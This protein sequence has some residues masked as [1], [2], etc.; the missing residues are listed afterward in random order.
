MPPPP[1]LSSAPVAKSAAAA[2]A[3]AR[4]KRRVADR[5]GTDRRRTLHTSDK[6]VE[7][8]SRAEQLRHLMQA[9]PLLLGS[10][11]IHAV[12]ICALSPGV[13]PDGVLLGWLVGVVCL[14]AYCLNGWWEWKRKEHPPF[15]P[16]R[17]LQWV[18]AQSGALGLAWGTVPAWLF[19][20]AEPAHQVLLGTG[21][22]GMLSAGAFCLA[23]VPLAVQA[24]LGVL[25]LG[26]L[27]AF[28]SRPGDM[29]VFGVLQWLFYAVVAIVA[30]RAMGKHLT[31]RVEADALNEH[32]Q[33]LIGLLLRDFEEQGSDVIWEI[34]AKGRLVQVSK[35]LADALGRP[36]ENV[37]GR[38]FLGLLADLQVSL[39]ENDRESA[40]A[41][42]NRLTEGQPFRDVLLP[43]V[44]RGSVHWW[45]VTAKPLVDDRRAALG[46]RGVARDVTQ[47]RMADRRL[48]WLA[49]YD[50]L[51]GLTNRAHFRVV[52]ETA[53]KTATAR[54]G[55]GAVMCL[56]LDNF[57]TVN[58]TLGHATGD[59]LL[60]EVG[61]RVKSA[62]DKTDVVARLGG[63]EFAVLLKRAAD[64]ATVQQVADRIILAMSEPCE[65]LGAVVPVRASIG[66]AR[67]PK[68]GI[69]VDEMMQHA[70]LALYDAKTHQPGSMRFFA[71][72]MGEQIRRRLVL[73]RD[74][75]E[76]LE[77][78]Q[79]SLHFQPKVDLENWEVQGFEA[80]LRWKH[81]EHG[82]IPPVEFIP[83][84]EESGLILPMGEW[85]L[86]EACRQAATWPDHLQVAVNISPVQVMAQN[87][88]NAIRKALQESRLQPDRL[89]LEITESV[90]INETSGTV[91]QLHALRKLGVQIALD[92]FGT[93]YSSLAYLRRFPFDTL[94]IDRAF[95][96]ELL[97][98]R[99][100]RAI[101]RNIL[102]LASSLRMSTV[103][104]GVEEPA[105]VTVL[106][107][108][109][110]NLVQGYF[111][112][113]PIPG[114][115]V[116]AFVSM[117][118]ERDRPTMPAD[119]RLRTT[120]LSQLATTTYAAS[121]ATTAAATTKRAALAT[122]P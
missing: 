99:D 110:C 89:E 17:R 47:S 4:P 38:P 117:W 98:S 26:A 52:L 73:E 64:E 76:A 84:A 50:T 116:L 74:L 19:T 79:L 3:V 51:T 10:T 61:R 88:P 57:K 39:P 32:Q 121:P 113:K 120:E 27:L 11:L 106:E 63:D 25:S 103:A 33:Q 44:V 94:K 108:E 82:D 6:S 85:A 43:L 72:R 18:A 77:R 78:N 58:D 104:E 46:W 34:D 83:V 114:D 28:L 92:D 86:Q 40:H 69:T 111:V 21:L 109:G 9:Q 15:V 119:F 80:L 107:N 118:S 70:D 56:D 30:A 105:Q 36:I 29:Q 67:F 81:P 54:A 68:D 100:A 53:L 59:A 41:L 112:S 122:T 97:T 65:V 93:G 7:A 22:V 12:V 62:I 13:L 71:S 101:V 35:R 37:Q 95:V 102:A 24:Y 23:S 45:S 55:H 8:R 20:Q 31:Q 87:L 91:D 96:R 66:I 2:T 48:A 1:K 115:Q 75:R 90:F 14:C 49:H 42:H 60:V 16:L 5:R